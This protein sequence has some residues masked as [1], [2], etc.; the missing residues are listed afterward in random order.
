[1]P[2]RAAAA[3]P[4]ARSRLRPRAMGLPAAAA[5]ALRGARTALSRDWSSGVVS[6]SMMGLQAQTV[7]GS[8]ASLI[9]AVYLVQFGARAGIISAYLALALPASLLASC[10]TAALLVGVSIRH[11]RR[12]FVLGCLTSLVAS[13]ALIFPPVVWGDQQRQ[14]GFLSHYFG[15]LLTVATMGSKLRDYPN[16]LARVLLLQSTPL[17]ASEKAYTTILDVMVGNALNGALMLS[18]LASPT[19]SVK[20]GLVALQVL[21]TAISLRG[22]SVLHDLKEARH[23][24]GSAAALPAV[25]GAQCEEEL[26]RPGDD[27]VGADA[28]QRLLRVVL[29]V[30]LRL[31][32]NTQ[33]WLLMVVEWCVGFIFTLNS[34][35]AGTIYWSSVVGVDDSTRSVYI[36]LES[37][38]GGG[39]FGLVATLHVTRLY[40]LWEADALAAIQRV[41]ASGA[42][43]GAAV[44]ALLGTTSAGALLGITSLYLYYFV[45]PWTNMEFLR[46][47]DT[48]KGGD[49]SDDPL[50]YMFLIKDIAGGLLN[51]LRNVTLM[52]LLAETGFYEPDCTARCSAVPT[53]TGCTEQCHAEA[54]AS[55][56]AATT[57]LVR[58]LYVVV[59]PG[60]Y[61]LACFI[62][63][64][65]AAAG[66]RKAR[67][68]ATAKLG[69]AP[70]DS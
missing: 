31:A 66:A 65:Y 58:A 1:M 11:A 47:L 29:P 26:Q 70:L 45:F 40:H 68:G 28:T 14:A 3:A 44:L 7:V 57:G 15:I 48:L 60:A 32:R 42:V 8:M 51:N 20:A 33:L 56:T 16:G 39:L 17:R 13:V 34:Q 37:A 4:P 24:C 62:M 46:L 22:A 10:L 23:V 41:V 18:L 35:A 61:L 21:S 50:V 9:Q 63:G 59:M 27:E 12:L 54:H 36:A 43:F 64:R 53:Q 30:A 55:V 67:A 49:L 25:I 6:I 38:L 5:K 19:A 52:W 2:P 69:F